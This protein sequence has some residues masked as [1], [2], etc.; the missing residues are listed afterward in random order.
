MGSDLPED[1]AQESILEEKRQCIE[2]ARSKQS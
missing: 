1:D 2:R